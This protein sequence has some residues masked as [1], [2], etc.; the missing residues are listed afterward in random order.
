MA[1]REREGFVKSETIGDGPAAI[2]DILE[3]D[4]N[5]CA[6]KRFK[7]LPEDA[8]ACEGEDICSVKAP[9]AGL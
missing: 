1:A 3:K 4:D 9:R 5:R 7:L 8:A 6:G 2:V